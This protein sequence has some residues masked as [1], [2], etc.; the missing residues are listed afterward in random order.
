MSLAASRV[1]A[2]R[3]LS[4]TAPAQ[5]QKRGIVDYLTNYPNKVR[6]FLIAAVLVDVKVS[7]PQYFDSPEVT[8]DSH[9]LFLSSLC[10]FRGIYKQT[11]KQHHE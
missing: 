8:L 10:L 2:Q 6:G 11:N 5:F 3:A 1:I 9:R 4:R 7:S